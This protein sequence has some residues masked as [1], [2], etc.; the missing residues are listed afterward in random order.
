[1]W[2]F[3]WGMPD[4]GVSTFGPALDNL[5]LV[6]LWITGIIFFATEIILLVFMVKYRHKEGRKAEYI[7]G[8]NKAEIIWTTIPFVIVMAL[9][10]LL[11]GHLGRDPRSKP[12][13]GRR[14]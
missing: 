10:L 2:Y 13:P 14:I 8:S 11:E 4:N 5:W 3:S 7:H 1:M 9:G 12:H 6:I